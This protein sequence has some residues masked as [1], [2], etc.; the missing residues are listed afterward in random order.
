MINTR[1]LPGTLCSQ[2]TGPH[3]ARGTGY[4]KQPANARVASTS[5]VLLEPEKKTLSTNGVIGDEKQ[6][7][8]DPNKVT[9]R[10]W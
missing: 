10:H 4:R 9:D 1:T 7:N 3:K 2:D 6:E 8:N 5:D